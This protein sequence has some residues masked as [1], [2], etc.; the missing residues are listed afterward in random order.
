MK[1]TKYVG[2]S[3]GKS[4]LFTSDVWGSVARKLSEIQGREKP[5]SCFSR[6]QGATNDHIIECKYVPWIS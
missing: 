5:C 2:V 4:K 6:S 3:S 1:A